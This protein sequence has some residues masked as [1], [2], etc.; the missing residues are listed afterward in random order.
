MTSQELLQFVRAD[1]IHMKQGLFETDDEYSTIWNSQFLGK[2]WT[3]PIFIF[4]DASACIVG[5]Y[6]MPNDIR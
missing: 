6:W 3:W 5:T 4:S 1:R 2:W